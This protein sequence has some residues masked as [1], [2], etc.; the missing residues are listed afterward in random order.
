M[1]PLL[2]MTAPVL[3]VRV[4]GLKFEYQLTEDDVKKVFA[5]YGE[6][7]WVTLDKEGTSASIQLADV[8]QVFAAQADLDN[9]Q[10]SGMSGAHLSV[11]FQNAPGGIPGAPPT[12][13]TA[14]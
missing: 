3:K 13:P 14:P 5:R 1:Q 9:K 12:A 11:E 8:N 4:E 6:V 7:R 2:N 10:L